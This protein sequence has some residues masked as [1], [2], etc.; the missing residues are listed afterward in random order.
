MLFIPV[1]ALFSTFSAYADDVHLAEIHVL[2]QQSSL[3]DFLPSTTTLTGDE[4]QKKRA[5]NLGDSLSREAGV[6]NAGF[7]PGSGRPVIRGLDR[8]SH[9]GCCKTVWAPWT[10]PRRV[11]ITVY[12]V[13]TLNTDQ[14]DIVPRTPCRFSMEPQPVGG[15]VNIS[16]QRIHKNFEAGALSQF[17]S[18][19]E[20]VYSGHATAARVDY[21]KK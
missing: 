6:N 11:W 15:V 1:F 13:D 18:Q 10:H 17:D 12:P 14:I 4:W 3:Y 7:G 20:N 5:S 16:N 21:G 8:G 9:P 19:Y 2:E